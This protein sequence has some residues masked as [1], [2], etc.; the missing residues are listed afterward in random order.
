MENTFEVTPCV[1]CG[2]ESPD[3]IE[4]YL[5]P[6]RLEN[7]SLVREVAIPLSICIECRTKHGKPVTAIL[8]PDRDDSV[9]IPNLPILLTA[10]TQRIMSKSI[11][12]TI[13]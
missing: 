3:D 11:Q 4:I 5:L 8:H 9:Y 13:H 2:T 6:I 10:P 12:Q 7:W 1:L